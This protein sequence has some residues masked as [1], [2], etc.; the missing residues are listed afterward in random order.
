MQITDFYVYICDPQ[1]KVI[2]GGVIYGYIALLQVVA[3]FLAFGIRKVQVKGLNDS[4]FVAA[5]IYITSIC[6]LI[7]IIVSFLLDNQRNTFTALISA[8]LFITA[9]VILGLV[10]IP[11][12]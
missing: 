5:T 1:S 9:T 7:F 12:V 10:F 2:V 4:L 11:K 6:A 8:G 3:L